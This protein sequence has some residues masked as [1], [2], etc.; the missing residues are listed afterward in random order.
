[1]TL[2][3]PLNL[4]A[5]DGARAEIHAQ[6][7]HLSRWW[8]AAGDDLLF[9]SA[10]SGF[11]PGVAIRGGV[12]VI[13]PQF[14]GEGPLPKHGFARTQPWTL[15]D[16]RA[17]RARLALQDNAAT[18]A[19]W[20]H[21]FGCELSIEIG[22]SQLRVSLSVTNSG[23]AA[24]LFTT[25]LH[26][27]LRVAAITDVRVLGLEGL[28]YRDTANGNAEAIERAEQLAIVGEVDRIYFDSPARLELVE[29]TRRLQIEQQG[30]S[31]TVVW[32]PGAEKGAALADMEDG[33]YQRMLCIE[34]AVIGKPV[35]LAPGETWSGSQTLRSS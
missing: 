16:Q 27:Y 22:G 34:A 1:M 30:F 18:R 2:P 23:D 3:A 14:A 5:A 28:R 4:H 7:A 12:P 33:G 19:I 6:G 11:A 31:D 9:L 15:V 32:N 35:H 20:P 21:A 10:R 29:P 13:F 25:A 8:N 26:T 24:M 17:D